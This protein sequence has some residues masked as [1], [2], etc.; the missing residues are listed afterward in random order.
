MYVLS[1][2]VHNI[3]T[4]TYTYLYTHMYFYQDG[5]YTYTCTNIIPQGNK[6]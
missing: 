6:T 4:L 2:T 5:T 3:Y 1:H